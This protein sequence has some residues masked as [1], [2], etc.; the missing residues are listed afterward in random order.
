MPTASLCHVSLIAVSPEREKGSFRGLDENSFNL[1]S[2]EGLLLCPITRGVGRSLG[3][4][5]H[6]WATKLSGPLL[7]GTPKRVHLDDQAGFEGPRMHPPAGRGSPRWRGGG[8]DRCQ[9]TELGF[10]LLHSWPCDHLQEAGSLWTPFPHLQ[11]GGNDIS[12]AAR[13]NEIHKGISWNSAGHGGNRESVFF[14]LAFQ[15]PV[16]TSFYIRVLIHLCFSV[17]TQYYLWARH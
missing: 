8:K 6:Q 14:S 1:F 15:I 4:V 12:R 11:E 13:P 16:K 3:S 7:L 17:F 2:L 9:Q 5:P 10:I